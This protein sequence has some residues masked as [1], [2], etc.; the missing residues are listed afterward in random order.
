MTLFDLFAGAGGLA[1]GLSKAG[2]DRAVLVERDPYACATI[3]KNVDRRMPNTTAWR[4]LE[5]NVADVDYST[6]TDEVDLLSAGLPCQ[7]FSVAG[8]GGAHQ[9]RRDMFCEVVRA[10]RDLKPKAILIENVKGLFTCPVLLAVLPA[11]SGSGSRFL[12]RA[13]PLG[14]SFVAANTGCPGFSTGSGTG[15]VVI[16]PEPGR[17]GGVDRDAR[18]RSEIVL[19]GHVGRQRHRDRHVARQRRGQGRRHPHR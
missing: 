15:F 17:R 12:T 18:Q 8:K 14:I 1:L 7:P 6:A 2:F 16:V 13:D 19:L 11:V 3:L 10:A 5:R 9:D 4:L